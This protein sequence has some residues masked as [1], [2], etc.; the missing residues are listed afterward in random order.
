MNPIRID[1]WIDSIVELYSRF[2]PNLA[3][4]SV[5]HPDA[6]QGLNARGILY[7]G[8]RRTKV[9][10]VDDK[11]GQSDYWDVVTAWRSWPSFRGY[12]LVHDDMLVNW[13]ELCDEVRLPLSS[14][15]QQEPDPKLTYKLD[16]PSLRGGGVE[17][18]GTYLSRQRQI[19]RT[20]DKFDPVDVAKLQNR[21]LVVKVSGVWYVPAAVLPKLERYGRM[22]WEENAFIE[23]ATP[24]LLVAVSQDGRFCALRGRL[25]WG[26]KRYRYK[27]KFAFAAQDYFHPVRMVGELNTRLIELADRA[28]V[29]SSQDVERFWGVCFTCD[30]YPHRWWREKGRFHSCRAG[31]RDHAQKTRP[32][33]SSG[34]VEIRN[35]GNM[36]RGELEHEGF[37]DASWAKRI[38][39]RYQQM[40]A[41]GAGGSG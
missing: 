2:V 6:P 31:C 3:F 22:L 21:G 30:E 20:L 37:W 36:P 25:D 12:M 27:T 5:L 38:F 26:K 14:V 9:H 39:G 23:N 33:G 15:W 1:L 17:E 19:R 35:I 28:Q 34:L 18:K 32:S 24:C 40:N 11:V 8:E 10:L 7:A 4:F 29:D 16:D 41:S 13:W